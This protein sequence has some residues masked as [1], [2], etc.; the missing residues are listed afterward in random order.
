MSRKT[1]HLNKQM[2][3]TFYK[4]VFAKIIKISYDFFTLSFDHLL[5]HEIAIF[6][7]TVGRMF[8]KEKVSSNIA[9]L[10]FIYKIY[11]IFM[12]Y[13]RIKASKSYYDFEV[14]Q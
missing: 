7:E 14:L 1:L 12:S 11:L 8:L 4:T 9:K 3:Y 13:I 2:K 5:L 6:R 10:L